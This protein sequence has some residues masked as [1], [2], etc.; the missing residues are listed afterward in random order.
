MVSEQRVAEIVDDRPVKLTAD[1]VAFSPTSD[2]PAQT[3]GSCFRLYTSPIARRSVCE[4]YAPDT[5]DRHVPPEATCAFWTADGLSHPRLKKKP[6]K[7]K[8]PAGNQH[9]IG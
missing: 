9:T 3:C 5:E 2:N 1:E 4:I 8:E 6:E 7:K